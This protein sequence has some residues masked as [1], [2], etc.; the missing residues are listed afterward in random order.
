MYRSRYIYG[1]NNRWT[2]KDVRLKNRSGPIQQRIYKCIRRIQRLLHQSWAGNINH[3]VRITLYT[4]RDFIRECF[5]LSPPLYVY[6]SPRNIFFSTTC[7]LIFHL[8]GH[9]FAYPIRLH[10]NYT[11]RGRS[12]KGLKT[13]PKCTIRRGTPLTKLSNRRTYYTFSHLSQSIARVINLN[14]LPSVTS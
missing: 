2:K 3:S 1:K 10:S 4:S 13:F 9:S 8:S 6:I 14:L 5:S 11:K 12:C 7:Q